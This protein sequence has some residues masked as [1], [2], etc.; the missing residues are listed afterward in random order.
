MLACKAVGGAKPLYVVCIVTECVYLVCCQAEAF[1]VR[2]VIRRGSPEIGLVVLF[3]CLSG[4]AANASGLLA[5]ESFCLVL[6][7]G[8][9]RKVAELSAKLF[10]LR[11]KRLDRVF[12][13]FPELCVCVPGSHVEGEVKD[14]LVVRLGK[15]SLKD[16]HPT[17]RVH[18]APLSEGNT[19]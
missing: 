14:N 11:T 8:V 3:L 6:R 5:W 12:G 18:L 4:A 2:A 15:Q 10:S 1:H 17:L 7:T 16:G 13:V 9:V 19:G